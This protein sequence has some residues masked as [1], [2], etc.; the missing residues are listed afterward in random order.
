MV[1]SLVHFST[2][3][4][5]LLEE[6]HPPEGA[7]TLSFGLSPFGTLTVLLLLMLL[8]WVAMNAQA[9]REDLHAAVH[10]EAGNHDAHGH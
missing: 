3:A 8:A 6:G 10:H 4:A 9:K 7:M 1:H 2:L 5:R